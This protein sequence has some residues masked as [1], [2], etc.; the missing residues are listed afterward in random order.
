M[1]MNVKT[2]A[3][4]ALRAVSLR[5]LRVRVTYKVATVNLLQR[6]PVIV[7]S[8]HVS[9]LDGVIV[10]FASPVPLTFGVDTDFSRRSK[11]ASM[12][13]SIL[14]WFGFGTVVPIDSNSPHGIRTLSRALENGESVM[15]FPEGGIGDGDPAPDKPGVAWLQK[16]TGAP[17]VWISIIGAEK[18]KLFAKSGNHLWPCI[19][20]KF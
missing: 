18:S 20:I 7:C 14:S 13:M 16:R 8:N 15:I 2:I 5:L 17:V 6:E 12:G 9:L 11:I 19:K 1:K 3:R 10:A 4:E